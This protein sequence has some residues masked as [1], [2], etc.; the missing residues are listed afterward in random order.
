[1]IINYI[2]FLDR[3]NLFNDKVVTEIIKF[4]KFFKAENYHENYYELNKNQPYCEFVIAPKLQKF[5]KNFKDK[6]V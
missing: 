4:D 5:Q 6:L 3:S 2:K 1:M